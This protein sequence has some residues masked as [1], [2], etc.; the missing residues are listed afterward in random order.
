[1]RRK[2]TIGLRTQLL[3]LFLSVAVPLGAMG[4]EEFLDRRREAARNVQEEVAA[5]AEA[6]GMEEEMLL[7]GAQ[8]LL[9]VLSLL[10]EVQ[11]TDSAPCEGLLA[12]LLVRY[13]QYANLGVVATDGSVRCSALPAPPGTTLADR[14]WF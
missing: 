4:V 3:L 11:S 5:L 7:Q 10:P 2:L 9:E 13:P 1:M 14:A 6:L 12:S 8:Q